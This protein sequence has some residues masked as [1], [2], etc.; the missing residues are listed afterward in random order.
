MVLNNRA[1]NGRARQTAL[2]VVEPASSVSPWTDR[3]ELMPT[4]IGDLRSAASMGNF[5]TTLHVLE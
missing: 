3:T 1:A 5:V 2:S 4:L